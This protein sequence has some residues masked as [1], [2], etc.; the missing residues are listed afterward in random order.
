[1][2]LSPIQRYPMVGSFSIAAARLASGLGG[3]AGAAPSPR[4]RPP[5]PRAA[6]PPAASPPAA[7]P[8]A[9]PR[10][11]PSAAAPPAPRPAPRPPRP[12]SAPAAAGGGGFIA[13]RSAFR[14]SSVDQRR[15][16]FFTAR[17]ASLTLADVAL[18]VTPF[19]AA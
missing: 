4:P 14:S 18:S 5:R 19:P 10:P 11:A 8:S 16:F 17:P 13:T 12:R 1:M 6:A 3:A 9:A 2:L 7:S 15:M